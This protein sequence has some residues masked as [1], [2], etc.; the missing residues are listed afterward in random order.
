M[1]ELALNCLAWMI[2]AQRPLSTPELQHALATSSKCKTRQDLHLDRPGVILEACGN[3]LE[4]ANGA[5]RPIHY[6][7]QE[8]LTT[9]AQEQSLSTVRTQLLDSSSMHARLSVAC[10]AYIHLSAFDRPAGDDY[11]LY[12]RLRDSSFA[13]Y[14]CQSFDY[15]IVKCS[16]ISL[17]AMAQLEKLF[18]QE[19]QYLAAVLQIRMLREGFDYG[20]VIRHF[21]RMQF[22]VSASTI[23]YSTGLYNVPSVRQRWV[24]DAPP[25]YA[26]H[27][28]SSAGLSSAVVRL[29]DA[30]CDTNERDGSGGTPLYHACLEAHLKIVHTLLSA[31]A[32]VNAQGEHYGNAL[33]AA[34]YGGHEAVVRLLL[35]KGADFNA[36]GGHYGNALRV[37]SHEGHEAVVRLLRDKGAVM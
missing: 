16:D 15:H 26:L 19:S 11:D 36:Q 22:L 25:T 10:L 6:T 14:A 9:A 12:S 17:D 4:E 27:L 3:L 1:R 8:F 31:S 35:D 32:D 29:L 20:S 28:A 7:V 23:V 13:G 24:G 21:D 33:Q 34:S 37:A 30:G 18:Q 5:I 2:Y